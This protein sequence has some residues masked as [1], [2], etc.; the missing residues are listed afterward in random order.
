M[1]SM[2]ST[3]SNIYS[4]SSVVQCRT[5]QDSSQDLCDAYSL[6]AHECDNT[7]ILMRTIDRDLNYVHTTAGTGDDLDFDGKD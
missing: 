6:E 3:I 4:E 5:T 7:R 2:C 1:D